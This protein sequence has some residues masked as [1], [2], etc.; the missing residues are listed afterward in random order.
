MVSWAD[1]V[2]SLVN[3]DWARDQLELGVAAI[4]DHVQTEEPGLQPGQRSMMERAAEERKWGV[5]KGE[6]CPRLSCFHIPGR[7]LAFGFHKS[8]L[9]VLSKHL[10]QYDL[11]W[12]CFTATMIPDSI[13]G[14]WTSKAVNPRLR[15]HPQWRCPPK[16]WD[17][18]TK[19]PTFYSAK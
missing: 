7:A 12:F 18:S 1:Q 9:Y 11:R 8:P 5:M 3:R 10:C 15:L 19:L 17:S 4:L 14:V 2:L 16:I 13:Y 6:R